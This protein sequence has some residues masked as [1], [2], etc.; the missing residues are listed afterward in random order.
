MPS[1]NIGQQQFSPW[2]LHSMADLNVVTV[3]KCLPHGVLFQST[4]N[5]I[6]ARSQLHSHVTGGGLQWIGLTLKIGNRPLP[7]NQ[8]TSTSFMVQ[9]SVFGHGSNNASIHAVGT[10]LQTC[11]T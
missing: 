5:E 7:A 1:I 4:L 3:T 11:Q 10:Q 9:H 8:Q 2:I 6:V